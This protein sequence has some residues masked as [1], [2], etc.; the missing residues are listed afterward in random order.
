M[1][2]PVRW[3]KPTVIFAGLNKKNL[4]TSA[5]QINAAI[6]DEIDG[7]VQFSK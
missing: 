4:K 7:H 5:C 2:K 1:S 3:G 6:L